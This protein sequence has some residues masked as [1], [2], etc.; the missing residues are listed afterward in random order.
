M[1]PKWLV[2]LVVLPLLSLLCSQ[3]KKV[4][5]ANAEGSIAVE[6]IMEDED[7]HGKMTRDQFEEMAVPILDRLKAA[8]QSGLQASG[9]DMTAQGDL[10]VQSVCQSGDATVVLVL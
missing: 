3:L 10:A 2:F 8:L 1:S 5:S 4:L 6:C 7:L 9:M